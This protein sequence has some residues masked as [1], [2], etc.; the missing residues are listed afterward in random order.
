MPLS[1]HSPSPVHQ[2]WEVLLT[3]RYLWEFCWTKSF[4][5]LIHWV[6]YKPQPG[7]TANQLIG[8]YRLCTCPAGKQMWLLFLD[9][10]FLLTTC[11]I[12]L[13]T[14]TSALF[15]SDFNASTTNRGF[16]SF[17]K[18]TILTTTRRSRGQLM[19]SFL[20]NPESPRTTFYLQPLA[21]KVINDPRYS[22]F[23]P[24]ICIF[25]WRP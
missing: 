11:T 12:L 3:T 21:Q 22:F 5:V 20:A 1:V 6:T 8:M 10:V 15:F 14:K 17:T 16:E 4:Y 23:C 7:T 19:I 24:F 9:P 2:S 25:S 13:L 18:C